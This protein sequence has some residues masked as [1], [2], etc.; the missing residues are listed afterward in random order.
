MAGAGRPT[1]EEGRGERARAWWIFTNDGP[2]VPE[3]SMDVEDT[4]ERF[5]GRVVMS[6]KFPCW[7]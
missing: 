3:C 2:E 4:L 1:G 5:G 6:K 7:Q